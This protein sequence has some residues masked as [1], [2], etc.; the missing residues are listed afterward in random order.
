MFLCNRYIDLSDFNV[1]PDY[2]N[3]RTFYDSVILVGSYNDYLEREID[4]LVEIEESLY[5]Y[6]DEFY[7]YLYSHTDLIVDKCYAVNHYVMKNRFVDNTGKLLSPR[8]YI[9]EKLAGGW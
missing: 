8:F 3:K 7:K 6:S 5:T 9:P 1:E 2:L 4:E